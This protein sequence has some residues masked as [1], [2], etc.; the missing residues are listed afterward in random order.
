MSSKY[1][2]TEEIAHE[3]GV[4][5]ETVRRWIRR[6]ALPVTRFPKFYRIKRED[7]EEFLKKQEV[8]VS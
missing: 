6:G 8:K 3:L 1:L 7:Y 2:T 5:I 4:H